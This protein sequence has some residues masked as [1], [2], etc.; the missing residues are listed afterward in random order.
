MLSQGL[1]VRPI[2]NQSK[3]MTTSPARVMPQ[4]QAAGEIGVHVNYLRNAM[5]AQQSQL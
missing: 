4:Y 1:P 5:S 3:K 2:A